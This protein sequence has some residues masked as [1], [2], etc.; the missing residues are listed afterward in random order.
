MLG[1][2]AKV[3]AGKLAQDEFG[4][5]GEEQNAPLKM[6]HVRALGNG[7]VQQRIVH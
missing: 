3:L 2:P 6:D 1:I 4:I 7:V 5:F